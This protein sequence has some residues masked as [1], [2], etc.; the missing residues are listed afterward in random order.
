[1]AT[2]TT[3]GGKN[4]DLSFII[5]HTDAALTRTQLQGNMNG[6]SSAITTSEVLR[7]DNVRDHLECAERA[8]LPV[9]PEASQRL[10]SGLSVKYRQNT[11]RVTREL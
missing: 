1:M 2:R 10:V 7:R 9:D 3:H 8:S 4:L 11:A 6:A 5:H